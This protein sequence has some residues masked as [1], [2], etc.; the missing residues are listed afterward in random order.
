MY[1]PM[2]KV[3]N[4]YQSNGSLHHLPVLFGKRTPKARIGT[5]SQSYQFRN[6]HIADVAFLCQH[7]ADN[8]RQ[9]LVGIG[10]NLLAL[11]TYLSAQFG[12]ESGQGAEQCGLT[13]SVS[14]QQ[15][16]QLATVDAC[17]DAVRHYLHITLT[18]IADRKILDMYSLVLQCYM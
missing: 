6:G 13:H 12:L 15:A 14:T 2:R 11:N 4:T 8:A 18:G 10:L 17:T 16:G 7:Y 1:H 3:R 5:A 9:L